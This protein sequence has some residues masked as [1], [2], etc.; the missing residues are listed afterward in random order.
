MGELVK[1]GDVELWV[2]QRGDGPDVLLIAGLGDVAEAWQAQL[3]E[4]SASYRV[5]AFDNRDVG[6]STI[7]GEPFTV[8]TMADDA[9][10]LLQALGIESAHVA[11]FSMGG[12][13]AQE[14]AL[15]HPEAVRTLVLNGTYSRSDA[16]MQAMWRYFRT[17]P[18]V[19]PSEHAFFE[20][21]FLWVYTAR[22]HSDGT[23]AA[24][25]EEARAFPH[26]Q[27][28]D[29][30]QRAVDACAAHDAHDRLA[31]IR[32]PALVVTGGADMVCPPHVGRAVADAIPGAGFVE[33]AGEAHQPFQEVA[34]EWNALV[35]AFWSADCRST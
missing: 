23:V 6:R 32:A 1:A 8:A 20:G 3:D 4:L 22:A 25:I 30:F 33:M 17:W 26:Q 10:A 29:A 16:Y 24:I 27:P 12:A 18:E 34:A 21:F 5:T 7:T 2:E 15:R 9:A 31:S 11:G 14:L 13:I 28:V 19:A 35:D